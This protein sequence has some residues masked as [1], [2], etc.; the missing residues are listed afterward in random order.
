[1][2][3]R[4]FSVWLSEIAWLRK[5]YPGHAIIASIMDDADKPDGWHH[6]AKK[7]QD[8]GA[9]MLEINMSCPHGMPEMGMG[10]AIGQNPELAA[11]VTRWTV[12][13]V[14]IPVIAKMTPNITDIGEVARAC[15]DA[16]AQSIS[17]VN[18]VAA[19]IGVDLET[20]T[21]HPGVAG[22]SAHGGL[23]GPAIKP[24]ALKAV[25]TIAQT[26]EAPISGIG[27]ITTWQDAAEFILLGATSLQVC[28][29]VM[30]R[31]YGI[32]KDLEEGLRQYMLRKG[33][34]DIRSMKGLSLDK[35]V[36]HDRLNRD[37]RLVSS[38]DQ[39]LC[40][41]CGLCHVSCRDAGYQAIR[42]AEDGRP[43]VDPEKCTGCALCQQVCPVRDCIIMV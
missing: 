7:C 21:P 18:T 28:S 25:A 16:G 15:L 37:V 33:F 27:G 31:G 41:K 14:D 3:D 30:N 26:V 13:A 4:E 22:Y 1:M 29:A 39:N 24:I 6:L 43:M 8:A 11:R 36:D 23:S 5:K 34:V 9:H 19:I 38:I 12:E 20:L 40:T 35:L 10:S 17:A 42:L 2:T 32:I